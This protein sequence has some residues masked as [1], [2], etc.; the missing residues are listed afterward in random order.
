MINNLATQKQIEKIKNDIDTLDSKRDW[1]L[2]GNS[3]GNYD[4]TKY[5]EIL[6]ECYF[7]NAMRNFTIHA[8]LATGVYTGGFF[9]N[10]AFY[11]GVTLNITD[12]NISQIRCAG[13]S[14]GQPHT[15]EYYKIY[16]KLK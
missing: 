14:N 13:M 5:S 10:S 7:D 2:I 4:F 12:T 6:V 9:Y 8:P 11:C 3:L 1:K 15:V 16:G